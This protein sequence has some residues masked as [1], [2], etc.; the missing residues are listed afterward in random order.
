MVFICQIWTGK[1]SCR[2]KNRRN[3]L[4]LFFRGHQL[5]SGSVDSSWPS[6]DDALFNGFCRENHDFFPPIDRRDKAD[7]AVCAGTHTDSF[8]IEM[9][10]DLTNR[11][12]MRGNGLK[13][14]MNQ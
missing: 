7:C 6:R 2:G 3:S 1:I 5:V 9:E 10:P 13:K 8:E 4:L 14:S 12:R 11:T